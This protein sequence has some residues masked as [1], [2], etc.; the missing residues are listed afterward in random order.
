[1]IHFRMVC[2]LKVVFIVCLP[3]P[4][5]HFKL[6]FRG[7]KLIKFTY[8]IKEQGG[9]QLLI[10]DVYFIV[11]HKKGHVQTSGSLAKG[12]VLMCCL[13]GSDSC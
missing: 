12:D 7:R 11:P 1:M 13:Y 9:C 4:F 3:Y 8:H 10:S 6:E 2:V 5:R